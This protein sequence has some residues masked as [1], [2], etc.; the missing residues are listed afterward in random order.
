MSEFGEVVSVRNVTLSHDL[1]CWQCKCVMS[2]GERAR[3]LRDASRR[4]RFV[5][6]STVQGGMRF[7]GCSPDALSEIAIA[8]KSDAAVREFRELSERAEDRA[9]IERMARR[10]EKWRGAVSEP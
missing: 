9:E 6:P 8:K 7:R 3:E 1:V 5:H 2:A 4:S 10:S